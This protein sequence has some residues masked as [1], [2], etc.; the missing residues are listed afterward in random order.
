MSECAVRAIQQADAH[1]QAHPAKCIF[2]I[3]NACITGE[4]FLRRR[5]DIYL[6]LLV[7]RCQPG[8]KC[9]S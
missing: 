3:G 2:I 9:L 7:K 5:L 6:Q 1:P 8:M 4:P